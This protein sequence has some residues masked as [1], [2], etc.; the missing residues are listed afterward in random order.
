MIPRLPQGSRFIS[1]HLVEPAH[2]AILAMGLLSFFKRGEANSA[3]TSSAKSGAKSGAKPVA[4]A[5]DAVQHLRLRARHR[6]I[7]AALLVGIGVIGFP[8]LF[9]TQPRPI[10]V[11]L[12]I[13]IPGKEAVPPLRVPAQ[14]QAPALPP[15]PAPTEQ[16]ATDN[17]VL[18][19]SAQKQ[20]GAGS[21]E[22]EPAATLPATGTVKLDSIKPEPRTEAK[23]EPKP[24]PKVEPKQLAKPSEKTPDKK[25]AEHHPDKAAS[26]QE[27]ARVQSLL[28]GKA[29]QSKAAESGQRAIVQVG[30]FADANAAQE[31]RIKVEKLGLKTYTQVLETPGGK[32]VR[33]R[34]GP[35]AS[36][37]EADKAAAKLRASGLSP[38]VLTL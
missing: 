37:D 12:P 17:P 29:G 3:A 34:V 8:L 28:E 20:V 9:E 30:A 33:V 13:D 5:A 35:F 14:L 2:A 15:L 4:D 7:G 1:L 25:V 18:P 31:V 23:A 21:A 38:A 26:Q 10:P 11:D 27:A 24:E 36:K 16:A 6:L 19:A 32:R 22:K